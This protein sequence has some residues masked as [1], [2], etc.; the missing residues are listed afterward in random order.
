[1][2]AKILIMI[3]GMLALT[4][5]QGSGAGCGGCVTGFWTTTCNIPNSGGASESQFTMVADPWEVVGS[6][7]YPGWDGNDGGCPTCSS[8]YATSSYSYV[9]TCSGGCGTYNVGPNW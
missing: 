2:K 4:G 6:Y 3:L 9:N 5:C 1:M 8:T 7:S